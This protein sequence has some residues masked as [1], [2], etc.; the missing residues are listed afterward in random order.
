MFRTR[1]WGVSGNRVL[2]YDISKIC[3]PRPFQPPTTTLQRARPPPG[4][5]D[6][7][8]EARRNFDARRQNSCRGSLGEVLYKLFSKINT[9]RCPER[10]ISAQIRSKPASHT[11]FTA[12]RR[13]SERLLL[14]PGRN[15]ACLPQADNYGTAYASTN[16]AS[17]LPLMRRLFELG[18]GR[19]SPRGLSFEC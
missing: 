17:V 14:N 2:S 1:V 19:A 10:V 4:T 18:A 12:G 9:S 5:R 15:P 11:L 13:R 8:A 3:L 6:C 16:T 7:E